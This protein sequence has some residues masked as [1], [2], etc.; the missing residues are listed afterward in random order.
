MFRRLAGRAASRP[1]TLTSLGLRGCARRPNRSL[2][3]VALLAA[4]SF[5]IVAVAANKLD[6]TRDSSQRS[7]GTGGFAFIGQSALPIV[8][9]LNSKA[10]RD[11][12]ALDEQSL[13]GAQV[14]PLRVHDGDDASCLNLNRA[15]TPRLL[16]VDPEALQSRGAFTFSTLLDPAYAGKPWKMLENFSADADEIPAVGDEATIEWGLHKKVGDTIELHR[17]ARTALQGAAGR[18][19][20]QFHFAGQSDN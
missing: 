13:R 9:D 2:A 18:G 11:F 20:G 4:G 16:G 6:A 10:G 3:T 8:Q 19:A 1:L 14:V 12:F 15:Q 7:S 5:L 17:R